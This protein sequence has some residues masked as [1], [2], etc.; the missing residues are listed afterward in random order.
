MTVSGRRHIAQQARYPPTHPHH[1]HTHLIQRPTYLRTYTADAAIAAPKRQP[2]GSF[3]KNPPEKNPQIPTRHGGGWLA[4]GLGS[5]IATD[6]VIGSPARPASTYS[7]M[8]RPPSL[9]VRPFVCSHGAF[10]TAPVLS[11]LVGVWR[12]QTPDARP[13]GCDGC[14]SRVPI[15][16]HAVR[17]L[18]GGEPEEAWRPPGGRGGFC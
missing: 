15:S 17:R 4:G 10:P 2:H 16:A 18:G 11:Q 12:V 6:G 14:G 13:A 1:A 5:A 7:F 9:F 3:G 8:F